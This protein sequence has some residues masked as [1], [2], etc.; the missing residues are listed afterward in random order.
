[1]QPLVSQVR[2]LVEALAYI[3]RPLSAGEKQSIDAAIASGGKTAVAGVQA[4][5]APHV[6]FAVNINPESRVKVARGPAAA[7]CVQQGWRAFLV[8]VHNE[9]GVTAQLKV[10]SPNALPVYKRSRGAADPKVSITPAQVGDRWMD[11]QAF[12]SR[13]LNKTLSGLELEYRIVEIYSRDAGKR[14]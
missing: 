7:E 9:A 10:K 4:V 2:R 5:L 11:V 8:R 12:D 13:P 14:E 3:G 1:M 6:L